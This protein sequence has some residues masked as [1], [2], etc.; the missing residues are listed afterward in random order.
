MTRQSTFKKKIRAR[1]AK[2]GERYAAARLALLAADT[3]ANPAGDAP[4][5]ALLDDLGPLAE[6][7]RSAGITDPATGRPFSEARLF[8]LSGGPGFM[9]FVFQYRGV[10][11]MLTFT[12]RSFSLPGPVVDRVLDHAGIDAARSETGSAARAQK[13][14]DAALARGQVAH[15]AVDQA[16][17]PWMGHGPEWYGQWP[18]H[19][20]VLG[21]DGD[22]YRVH[23]RATWTLSAE[24]LAAARAGVKKAKHRLLTF[25]GAAEA[26]P[27]EATRRAL[28]FY[29]RN[30]REAPFPQ[31]ANNFG[32]A[33]IARTAERMADRSTKDGWRRIFADGPALF[34]ALW[35]V[36][37]CLQV[38]LTS[39]A[40]GRLL[41]AEFLDDASNLAGLEG[42]AAAAQRMRG[43]AAA[44]DA[45]AEA[46]RAAGGPLLDEAIGLT[47]AIDEAR[48]SGDAR[49]AVEVGGWLSERQGLGAGF[50]VDE[51]GRGRMFEA[52]ADGMQRWC[53]AE[54]AAVAAIDDLLGGSLQ[55]A[56]VD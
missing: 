49:A 2:T 53:A 12:C 46:A 7:L 17:L 51:A 1:M 25:E 45:V 54:E 28:A 47:E 41:F 29:V 6:A 52:L 32:L 10:P 16:R 13:A 33:G 27:T 18:R 30:Q 23:D 55:R 8:G 11:P 26:D 24:A 37:A 42:L 22:S 34:G 39:P 56:D 21:R 38:E 20:D 14:L 36:W 19:I 3:A 15:V 35:R 5:R 43:C 9:A 40:G 4:S 44:V 48:R 31:F 50:D